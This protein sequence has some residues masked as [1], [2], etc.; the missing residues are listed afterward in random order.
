MELSTRNI[1]DFDEDNDVIIEIYN[2]WYQLFG[3]T[4]LLLEEIP[5]SRIPYSKELIDL[6]NSMLNQGLRPHL[7]KWQAKYRSWYKS[8]IENLEK[9]TPQEYQKEYPDYEVLLKDLLDTNSKMLSIKRYMYE[10]AFMK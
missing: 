9:M 6:V 2:S 3:I 1:H 4:R 5:A 10:I 7:S 8:H